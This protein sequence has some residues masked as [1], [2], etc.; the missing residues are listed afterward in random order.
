MFFNRIGAKRTS[1]RRPGRAGDGPPHRAQT[2]PAQPDQQRGPLW[3]QSPCRLRR[4]PETPSSPLLMTAR[5]YPRI[6]SKMSLSLSYGWKARAVATPAASDLDWR[7]LGRSW[8]PWR[9]RPS[10]TVP[11]AGWRRWCSFLLSSRHRRTRP[12]M[13]KSIAAVRESCSSVRSKTRKNGVGACRWNPSTLPSLRA[14]CSSMVQALPA[15][16]QPNDRRVAVGVRLVCA[17]FVASIVFTAQAQPLP[18]L[19]VGARLYAEACSSCH[20]NGTGGAAGPD[21]SA[22]LGPHAGAAARCIGLASL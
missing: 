10:R 20:G 12:Q 9:K 8:R 13:A 16:G 17:T 22:A 2:R 1:L 11:Q 21:A 18:D 5:V 15:R 4:G 3:R 7:S 14:K 19:A 6:N